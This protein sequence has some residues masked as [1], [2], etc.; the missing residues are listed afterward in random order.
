VPLTD[1]TNNAYQIKIMQFHKYHALGNDYLV[2]DPG[3]CPNEPDSETIRKICHRNFGL[4]S[5]GILYGPLESS[6]SDC[7]LKIF[8]PDGS[9]AEKSGNGLRI[10]AR[11]LTDH[12]K[13]NSNP[14]TVET[15]GG[16]VTI[17]V[18]NPSKAITVDMGTVRFAPETELQI[19]DTHYHCH[20]A[21]IGNP[22]CVIPVNSLS[23][24][25]THRDGPLIETH[26]HFPNRTNVQFLK[27]LD[28][29]NIQIE[30]WERGAGYTLAS[31]SSSSAAAAVAHK[32]G[33]CD[34]IISVHMPGG[35][36]QI[37][38]DSEY[39][40]RM[41]GPTTRVGLFE[42]NSEALK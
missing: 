4:G 24:K 39:N 12:Q 3:V 42:L 28:R 21:D 16:Q 30:I 34:S 25:Q 15:L 35:V 26:A 23:V 29:K 8:N 20:I 9:E 17:D 32:L 1:P 14:F 13:T 2:L 6:H 37:E 7:G 38:I 10:F 19:E 41:T 5:D 27:I 18:K 36:I 11:Y 31:G 40:I 33:L 22:H